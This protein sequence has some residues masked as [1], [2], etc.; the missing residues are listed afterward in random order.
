MNWPRAFRVLEIVWIALDN[1]SLEKELIQS[2]DSELKLA[3]YKVLPQLHQ[4]APSIALRLQRTIQ[5]PGL[6]FEKL[7]SILCDLVEFYATG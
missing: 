6:R 1:P 3:I 5:L 2:A 4:T 7:C